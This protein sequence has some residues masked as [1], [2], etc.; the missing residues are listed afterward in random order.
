[1]TLTGYA[2]VDG[3]LY[4]QATDRLGRAAGTIFLGQAADGVAVATDEDGN[5]VKHS[6]RDWV[7]AWVGSNASSQLMAMVSPSVERFPATERA[8]EALNAYALLPRR[9]RELLSAL[10]ASCRADRQGH[11]TRMA[12]SGPAIQEPA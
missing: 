8:I 9:G 2:L 6:S 11:G 4:A 3:R 12:P 10:D 5:V 7:A 1:M